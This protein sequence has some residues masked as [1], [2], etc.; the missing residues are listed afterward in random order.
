[1]RVKLLIR[2]EQA[3]DRQINNVEFAEEQS[4]HSDDGCLIECLD[5]TFLV[6]GESGELRQEVADTHV[7]AE[8]NIGEQRLDERVV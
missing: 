3:G 7:S 6:G 5:I 8:F 1:M 2:I 4:L